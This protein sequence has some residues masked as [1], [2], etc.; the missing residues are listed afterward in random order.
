VQAAR[1]AALR[2]PR[3][4]LVLV[5]LLTVALDAASKALVVAQLEGKDSIRLLGGAVT[6]VVSRNSGAA[7][8]FAQG[9][10]IVFTAV[11]VGV[12]AYI[13]RTMPR[14]RSRGWAVTL[15]LLLGGAVGNLVDRLTRAPGFGRGWVVDFISVPH[16]ASFNVADS[17]ITVGAALAILLSF[18]GIE[19]DGTRR[20]QA[21]DQ[22]Q[23][24]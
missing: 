17:A 6:L 24:D 7:F 19:V 22:N 3:V 2:A 12:I 1:G 11:A 21:G 4:L 23:A 15:G 5:A 10:T 18:R 14:L 8:S 13:A 9:M 20:A 16:F